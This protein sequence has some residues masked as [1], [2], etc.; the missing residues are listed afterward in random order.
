VSYR[1]AALV[2]VLVA[3]CFDP[4]F[5]EGAACSENDT[6]PPGQTCDGMFCRVAS[7]PVDAA[8]V[9]ASVSDGPVVDASL[10][11]AADVDA[12]PDD[13]DASVDATI[14]AL[15]DATIDALVDATVDARV[16]AAPAATCNALVATASASTTY[17][18]YFASRIND[19]DL[20]TR[21]GGEY[22]W[23]NADG[24]LPAWV[25]LTMPEPC[26]V[27]GAILTTSAGHRIRSYQV[28]LL[29][30]ESAQW[31]TVVDVVDNVDVTRAHF[32]PLRL[33]SAVRILGRSGPTAQPQYARV[34][35]LELR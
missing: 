24:T 20:D 1:I 19:N 10:A 11:D 28:Q 26:T 23:C 16:D 18:D 14:D 4:R 12:G 29:D 32:F 7:G 25:Q 21:T 30:V 3:G 8:E 31:V 13:P 2:A 22:S 34:N 17:P 33:V 27:S 6:C 15:V 5:G 35:E 9:D